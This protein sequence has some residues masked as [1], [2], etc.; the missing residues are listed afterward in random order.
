MFWWQL[1]WKDV[2]TDF[3]QPWEGRRLEGPWKVIKNIE[4]RIMSGDLEG[5]KGR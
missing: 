1:V 5:V 3:P 4:L 2:S